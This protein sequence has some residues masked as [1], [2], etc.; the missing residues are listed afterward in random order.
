VRVLLSGRVVHHGNDLAVSVELIDAQDD[1]QIWGAQYSR[2]L[3]DIIA[4]PEEISRDTAEKLRLRLSGIEQK[5][6][7]KNYATNSEA[8]RLCLQGRYYWNQRTAEGLEQGSAYFNQVI[9]KDPNYAPAYTGLADCYALLNVYNVV[10]A[11]EVYPKAQ[12]AAARALELD[13]SLAEA[14][15]SLAFVTY[16][17]YWDWAQAEQ[18]FKRAIELKSDYATAHQWYSALLA[19]SSRHTEAGAGACRPYCLAPFRFTVYSVSVAHPYS[20]QR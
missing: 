4:L 18:H 3:S 1:S 15:T 14:H 7:T 10:A 8:Y 12:A 17:Y 16:R 5:Q 13:E 6:L 2:K 11:T 19:S 9:S 20:T